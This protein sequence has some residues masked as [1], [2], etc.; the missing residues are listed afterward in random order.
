MAKKASTK[1]AKFVAKG[2]FKKGTFVIEFVGKWVPI[3]GTDP[4]EA[5]KSLSKAD[6]RQ[7]KAS[8]A[9]AIIV[10]K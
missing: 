4:G 9:N 2:I 1:P 10:N 3:K 5:M 7:A 8:I 6:L